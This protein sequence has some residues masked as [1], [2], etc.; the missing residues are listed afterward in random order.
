MQTI[1]G[2]VFHGTLLHISIKQGAP[3]ISSSSVLP[4]WRVM[5]SWTACGWRTG[6]LD[7]VRLED[8]GLIV[9]PLRSDVPPQSE[10]L[11][12]TLNHLLPRVDITDLLSEVNGWTGFADQFTHLHT[13][14][15]RTGCQWRLLPREFPSWNT[16]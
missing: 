5:A 8:G 1:S 14:L 12:W 15:L 9:P 6:K 11:K 7:G 16:V 13:H 10:E 2:L 4:T 3:S